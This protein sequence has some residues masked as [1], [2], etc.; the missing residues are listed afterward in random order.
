MRIISPHRPG[1]KPQAESSAKGDAK[2]GLSSRMVDDYLRFSIFL[3]LIGMGYIWNAYQA[4]R[5]VK[6]L[7]TLKKEVKSLKSNF[8]LKQAML[9]AGIRMSEIADQVDTLGIYPL[10]EPAYKIISGLDRPLS[11]LLPVAR[12]PL[13][14][15]DATVDTLL[16]DSL[17]ALPDSVLIPDTT[18]SVASIQP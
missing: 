13:Q 4:E 9:G 18:R 17:P 5:Q 14:R 2:K 11:S 8:M 10:R 12:N 16:P 1:A 15:F 7:E 3:T 6:E